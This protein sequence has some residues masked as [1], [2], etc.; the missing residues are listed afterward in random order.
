MLSSGLLHT[1]LEIH[2]LH[3]LLLFDPFTILANFSPSI[4]SLTLYILY[5]TVYYSQL[6][7]CEPLLECPRGPFHLNR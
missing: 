5:N 1:S 6:S 2:A 7:P 4:R 3:L